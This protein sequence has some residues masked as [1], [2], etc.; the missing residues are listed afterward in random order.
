MAYIIKS[1]Y[2]AGRDQ[3][4]ES[5]VLTSDNGEKNTNF[6]VGDKVRIVS[7][8]EFKISLFKRI[9]LWIW[10]LIIKLFS[11][12]INPQL[13]DAVIPR[14]PIHSIKPPRPQRKR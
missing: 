3:F 2:Y 9:L 14:G 10:S 4:E 5:Y 13:P 8:S 1:R 11:R 6:E 12:K 7:M